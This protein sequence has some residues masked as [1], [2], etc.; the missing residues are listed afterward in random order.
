ME[1]IAWL[2]LGIVTLISAI[3]AH[4][5]PAA[6]P[7]GRLALGVLYVV[8]GAVVHAVY[9]ATGT[10]YATFADAAHILFVRTAWHAV[11]APH[12]TFFIGLLM[13]FESVVGVLV[14]LGGRWARL[15]MAG[16][17]GMQACLL[18]FGWVITAFATVMLVAVGLLLRAQLRH[19][20]GRAA[21]GPGRS[22]SAVVP[23]GLDGTRP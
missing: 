19:D 8:A 14:L 7:V 13:V 5:R 15:G 18:L 1:K 4:W 16:I 17:L 6:L 3:V 9:L 12:Q 2:I 21:T 23:A 10:S 22:S 20:R 11:V